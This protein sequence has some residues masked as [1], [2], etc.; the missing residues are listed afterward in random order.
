VHR[1]R[2]AL[3][4][5]L[6]TETKAYGFALVVWGTATLTEAERGSPGKMGVIAFVGGALAVMGAVTLVTVGGPFARW[7]Q[8]RQQ[9]P[10]YAI[11][12]VHVLSVAAAVGAGWAVTLVVKDKAL[13]YLTSSVT[14]VLIYQLV[15][16]AELV[17]A[18]AD[19]DANDATQRGERNPP[20]PVAGRQG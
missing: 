12:S 15:L 9:S 5:I 20:V 8:R 11:G 6:S 4:S 19:H 14:A 7:R 13:A 1:Y 3:R 18:R 2:E 10:R 16:G 17:L